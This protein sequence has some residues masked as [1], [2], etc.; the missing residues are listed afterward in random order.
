VSHE[1]IPGGKAK[2]MKPSE[3]PRKALAEGARH[4][5]EHTTSKTVATEIAMD[6][7]VEDPRYYEKLDRL[8]GASKK[9]F[10]AGFLKGAMLVP[11]TGLRAAKKGVHL[12]R[13]YA[14]SMGRI[15]RAGTSLARQ[16]F[17]MGADHA[18]RTWQPAAGAVRRGGGPPKSQ[19]ERIMEMLH[20]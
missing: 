2:G 12:A 10:A 3:F 17:E 7:L 19:M 5:L 13:T 11:V 4:E 9:A 1:K 16:G 8:E 14:R 18:N 20:A 6:H 15:P